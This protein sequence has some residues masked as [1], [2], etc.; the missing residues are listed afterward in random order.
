[1]R[2]VYLVLLLVVLLTSIVSAAEI[3]NAVLDEINEK[4]SVSVIVVLKDDDSS[5]QE[6]QDE[7]L[8]RVQE[9][10]FFVSVDENDFQLRHKYSSLN[11]FSA[12]V[13]QKILNRLEDDPAVEK[14]VVNKILHPFLDNSVPQINGDVVQAMSINGI[15]LTGLG[16]TV[17]VIDT[18]IDTDHPAFT[19]RILDQHCFCQVTDGG[20]GGCCSDATAENNDAE[21]VHGHG[22][23]VSGIAAGNDATYRG[24]APEAGIVFV[25]VCNSVPQAACGLDDVMA[26]V[27]WCTNNASQ[28]NVSVIS[29]SLGDGTKNNAYCNDDSLAPAINAAVEKDISVVIASGN[30][31]YSDGISAPACIENAIP[32]GAV[33]SGDALVYNRG[34]ILDIV[35]PGILISAPY[36][37]GGITTL[38]GTSMATPHAAGVVALLRQYWRLAYDEVPSP[39]IIEDKLILTGKIIEESGKNYSRIDVL[40]AIKPTFEFNENSF[41]NNGILTANNVLINITSDVSLSS[42]FLEWNYP[43]GTIKN[44]TLVSGEDKNY[45]YQHVDLG[46][47]NYTY[48]VYGNDSVN[49]L[50]IS[51]ERKIFADE[52]SPK[53]TINTPV[54]NIT[55]GGDTFLLNATVTDDAEISSVVFEITKGEETVILVP[56]G[57]GNY[58]TAELDVTTLSD[59]THT[60]TVLANDIL[61]NSNN[62][63]S[64]NFVVDQTG[65]VVSLESPLNNS[66]ESS[67]AVNLS[68]NVNDQLSGV[69]SCDLYLNGEVNKTNFNVA[70]EIS[71]G[72]V[73]NLPKADYS[74]FVQCVDELGNS[75]NSETRDLSVVEVKPLVSLESPVDNYL[76]AVDDLVFT[77]LATD[78]FSLAT[79][80]LYGD[81]GGWGI[82]ETAE[83]SGTSNSSAFNKVIADGTYLWNCLAMDSNSNQDFAPVNRT[84]VV[85]TI[86]PAIDSIS[87][88]SISEDSAT[89][90]WDTNENADSLVELW[91]NDSS[92]SSESDGDLVSSH[93]ISLTDLVSFTTYHYN[94]ASCDAVNHCTVSDTLEFTTSASTNDGDDD[95]SGDS[96]SGDSSSASSSSAGGSGG[97]SGNSATEEEESEEITPESIMQ[98]SI[99]PQKVFA[100]D[101]IDDESSS[102]PDQFSDRFMTAEGEPFVVVIGVSSIPVTEIRITST[103][104]KEINMRVNAPSEKPEELPEWE[105]VYRYL[106]INV[107][108]ENEE[109]VDAVV[110]FTVPQDWLAENGVDAEKIILMTFDGTEWKKLRTKLISEDDLVVYEATVKHFSYFAIAQKKSLLNLNFNVGWSS[111][112]TLILGLIGVILVITF[113]GYYLA[114]GGRE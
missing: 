36:K 7:V 114:Y 74:W 18:G 88:D 30:N 75:G 34:A 63:E 76:S 82:K 93:S 6:N 65:P 32:I 100:G 3:E 97:S 42:A 13:N 12:D 39:K 87:V 101:E 106:E 59:G 105:G 61:N 52:A 107:D 8:E 44:L 56:V 77:C 4:G 66:E 58:W 64:V 95:T 17:C 90:I 54:A 86:A 1:M 78:T 10:R 70:E 46:V 98:R 60:L 31:E 81:W 83:V 38:S 14:V 35:A 49:T 41:P 108:L 85:D 45:Y 2:W 111:Q 103:I 110:Q 69:A 112:T 94:V 37:G 33:N 20:S 28:Y 29:I 91:E 102:F 21:D 26:G 19:G 27:E 68:F 71:Q 92:V 22:T 15:N 43:N 84:F 73:V 62:G 47:N 113:L 25:K 50:G 9:R 51:E 5:A 67:S 24:V 80:T 57:F 96:S 11:S 55:L 23:H 109:L 53:V 48:Q 89:I 72:F 16:E 40:A 99:Q 104:G 79:L